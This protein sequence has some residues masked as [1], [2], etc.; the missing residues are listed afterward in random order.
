MNTL[1]SNVSPDESKAGTVVTVDL[2]VS[3]SDRRS[4]LLQQQNLKLMNPNQRTHIKGRILDH[5]NF[6]MQY[7]L[8]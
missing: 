7:V 3:P 6:S 1:L 8:L 2:N 5:V 4:L